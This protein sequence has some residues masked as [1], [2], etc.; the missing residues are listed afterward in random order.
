M[1]WH[2]PGC[3]SRQDSQPPGFGIP[4]DVAVSRIW[5]SPECGSRQDVAVSSMWQYPGS[6]I[7]EDLVVTCICAA[8]RR[9]G[10]VA[11]SDGTVAGGGRVAG[12][13]KSWLFWAKILY[14]GEGAR[15]CACRAVVMV[16][17][18][19]YIS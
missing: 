2:F 12:D 10:T 1:I 13:A 16:C 17:N 6:D 11:A 4:Q 19:I 15:M 14:G 3:G 8:R 7:V 5:Y 18:K 9:K